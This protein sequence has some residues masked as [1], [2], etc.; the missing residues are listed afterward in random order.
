V[1]GLTLAGLLMFG[2]EEAIRDP[3]A[4]PGFSL[5]Y[6]ERLSDDPDRRWTDRLASD[7]KWVC[8]IF[9]FYQ[10]VVLRLT[11][12]LKVPFE[13]TADLVRKDDTI[14][15]QAVREA[16]VNALIHGDYLGQGGVIVE[17]YRDR[18]VF[19]NPGTLL[20]D[21]EQILR[22]GVSEC[23]NRTLQTMFSLLGYGEKAG[24]GYDK[25][26]QGWASQQWRRPSIAETYRSDRVKLVLPMVS[27]LPDDSIRRLGKVFGDRWGRLTALE[28]QALITAEI[29]GRVSNAQL[30]EVSEEH[31]SD[32]TRVLQSLTARGF[33]EQVGQKRGAFYRLPATVTEV[34]KGSSRVVEGSS[35]LIGDPTH[36][37]A[38]PYIAEG[39]SVHIGEDSVHIRGDSVHWDGSVAPEA[40][41]ALLAI[42]T[43]ARENRHLPPETTRQIV[44]SLCQGRFLTLRQM[45]TLLGRNPHSLGRRFLAPLV[46]DGLLRLRFPAETTILSAIPDSANLTFAQV[47][48]SRT[49]LI[50]CNLRAAN[51][52]RIWERH[53]NAEIGRVTRHRVSAGSVASGA[54]RV[55]IGYCRSQLI[56]A[57]VGQEI[58]LQPAL[59]L[60]W[61]RSIDQPVREK[62]S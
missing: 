23:R 27:I 30:R 34:L 37:P 13:L 18:F 4:I 62:A 58:A 61:N 31:P 8:N 44:F 10:R 32:L 46:R 3:E 1:S 55:R 51:D 56:P 60:L 16:L 24:S 2:K 47:P 57:L 39:D 53:L 21:V 28:T 35:Q 12:D 25:I 26:R 6:R 9:Q 45:A 50:Q 5:D 14:V 36:R 43:A 7:G 42:A 19:S 52:L 41:P 49:R 11:A 33:L 17:K 22:G 38:T 15:H 20:L 48:S 40:D 29:D 59:G 54:G